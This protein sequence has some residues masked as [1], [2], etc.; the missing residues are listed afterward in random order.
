M[1]AIV[2]QGSDFSVQLPVLCYSVSNV[3]LQR[4]EISKTVVK[5]SKSVAFLKSHNIKSRGSLVEFL[6][7]AT[8][9][10]DFHP[11]GDNMVAAAPASRLPPA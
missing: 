4:T 1:V 2:T 11:H 6:I 5:I 7:R 10:V 9:H 3:W 8:W